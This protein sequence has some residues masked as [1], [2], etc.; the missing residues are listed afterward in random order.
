MGSGGDNGTDRLRYTPEHEWIDQTQPRRVR[1]GITE[2]A[3]Q[4][5]GDVVFVDLPDE[6]TDVSAGTPM[7]EVESTKSVSDVF[8]PLGGK[9]VAVNGELEGAPELVNQEPYGRGWLVEIEVPEG[10][11]LE[12]VLAGMLDA[13]GYREVTQS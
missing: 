5:L 3:Q 12:G 2:Y 6:G 1:V 9:V 13:A 10:S 4:Q 8:A 11:D 7:G